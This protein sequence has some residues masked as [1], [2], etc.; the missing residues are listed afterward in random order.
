V[1]RIGV[2]RNGVQDGDDLP[3][4]ERQGLNAVPVPE[5]GFLKEHRAG[6]VA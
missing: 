5:L 2:C 3:L 6:A 1:N 4:T